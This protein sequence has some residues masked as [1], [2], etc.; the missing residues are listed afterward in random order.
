[1]PCEYFIIINLINVNAAFKDIQ[2]LST[3]HGQRKIPEINQT[4]EYPADGLP[5]LPVPS[6]AEMVPC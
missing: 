6:P 1:M 3:Q 5:L 2:V 4:P